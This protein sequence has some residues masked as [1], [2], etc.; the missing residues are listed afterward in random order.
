M[1]E[2]E[3]RSL[4]QFCNTN[5][6]SAM[7]AYLNFADDD[8]ELRTISLVLGTIGFGDVAE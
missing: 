7:T 8:L 3:F 6:Y 1:V 5:F 4:L 2:G